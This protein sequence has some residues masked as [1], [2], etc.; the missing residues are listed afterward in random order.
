M[1]SSEYLNPGNASMRSSQAATCGHVVIGDADLVG[2][3]QVSAKREI[4]D[5]RP[6][7]CHPFATVQPCVQY[8]QRAHQPAMQERDLVRIAFLHEKTE[9]AKRPG[10]ARHLLAVEEKPAHDFELLGFRLRT[11]LAD[12]ACQICEDRAGLRYREVAV[13]AV[14]DQD[15][16][17]AHDVQRAKLVSPGFAG[18]EGDPVHVP[19][20]A[21]K[22]KHQRRFVSVSGFAETVKRIFSHARG[23]SRS[24]VS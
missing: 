16:H 21:A 1:R 14:M 4:G 11:E 3:E 18:K 22:L 7:G 2:P 5:G 24:A 10:I 9:E 6:V 19:V 17:L 13:L 23:S 8:L 15:R 12:M 20:G